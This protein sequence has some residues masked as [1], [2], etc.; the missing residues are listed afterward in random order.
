MDEEELDELDELEL[1]E[2]FEESEDELESDDDEDDDD[3][4]CRDRKLELLVLT[5]IDSRLGE[6]GIETAISKSVH[7]A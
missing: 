3:D 4:L 7:A 2:L 6:G 5:L 1:D